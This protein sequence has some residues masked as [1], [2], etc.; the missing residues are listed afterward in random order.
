MTDIQ[1]II[2]I[3]GKRKCGKD[4]I[5]EKL[6]QRLG[7][8]CQIVR[9]S[10]PIKSEWAKKMQLDL[11]ELLSDGPYKEKYR[12]AMIDWSD[13]VRKQCYGY[14]CKTA[15]EKANSEIIVVSDVRRMNDIRY[16][17]ETYGDK[18]ACMR[19]TCPDSIRIERGF[20]YT[21]G[22]DDIESE[23]GLDN[24]NKWDLVLENDNK[25]SS[26][27]LINLIIEKFSL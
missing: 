9:I 11:K 27:H 14:F 4:F 15:M 16:F 10:E 1:R 25:L 19:L 17:H 13:E 7:D 24:Y 21:P 20:V 12:K 26:D 2:L 3:S 18:V 5:S 23:C 8:R 22:I 6:K